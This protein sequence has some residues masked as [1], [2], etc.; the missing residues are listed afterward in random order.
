MPF[1]ITGGGTSSFNLTLGGVTSGDNG[2]IAV[3]LDSPITGPIKK[4]ATF[5]N[6]TSTVVNFTNLPDGQ[7]QFFT[8][9]ITTLVTTGSVS[10]DYTGLMMPEPITVSGTTNKS[11]NLTKEEAGGAK[12]TITVNITGDLVGDD[13][14]IFAGSPTGFKVKTLTATSTNLSAQLF[15]PDGDW[16]VGMG[17]AMPKDPTA[18][19]PPMPDW[20]PPMPT[21]VK[22]S[23]S[24]AVIK[25]SSGTA[26][27]GIIAINLSDQSLNTVQGTVVDGS[28]VGIANAEV[29]AYQANGGFGG[30][31]T[32]TAS[33]GS[34]TLKIPVL[35]VYTIGAFKPGL[36]N[37]NEQ[38]LN[39]DGN[40]SG[41][42][43]KMNKPA[44]TISGKVLN[45]SGNGI[46]Y[47]PVWAYKANGPGSANATTDASGNYIIYVN[48][49]TWIL[50]TDAPGV[51]WME[52]GSNLV[53]NGSSLS[54]INIK[55]NSA[56]TYYDIE[57]TI[58]ID[59]TTQTYMP[60]RAVA[61]DADGNHL[62]RSYDGMTD[63]SGNYKISAPA[64]I[65]RVDIW[66]PAYGEIERTG[67]D[68][69]PNHPANV[70]LTAGNKAGVDITIAN[71]D[72]KTITVSVTNGTADYEG[73]VIIEGV[74]MS[75]PDNPKPTNYTRSLYLKDLSE[76]A[77]IKLEDNKH[78]LFFIDIPGLGNYI[79]IEGTDAADG[80]GGMH[81]TFNDIFVNGVDRN[82][83][84]SIPDTS[85][86][87]NFV[88]I[89]GV[90]TSGGSNLENAWVWVGNPATGFNKGTATNSS[91]AYSITLPVLTS[92]YYM[93][94]ADKPGYV[95]QE[96]DQLDL[97][98][99]N[100]DGVADSA[101]NFTLNA[102]SSSISGYIY[103]DANSNG[104]KDSGEE[105]LNGWVY[106][107]EVNTGLMSHSPVDGSGAYSLGVSNGNWKVFGAADAY[108][109]TQYKENGTRKIIN[110][111]GNTSGK[112]IALESDSN[113]N[114]K[115]KNKPIT[116]ANGGVIDDTA[117]DG[118]GVKITVPANALGSSSS[119]G[120][121]NVAET[122][123]VTKTNSANPFGGKGK[124]ITA[125]DN[126]G[127]PITNL[128]DYIDIEMVYW[129]SDIDAQIDAGKLA[130]F[131]KIKAMQVSYFDSSVNDWVSLP[132]TR[133]AYYKTNSND[134]E[135]KTYS[136]T[137]S[138]TG[139]AK[140]IDDALVN[141]T[142]T[143][144]E[145][146]KLVFK[147]STNHLTIFG[148][149]TPTDG[150]APVAP[151][152]LAQTSGNG[153]SVALN[154]DDNS[155]S[156]LLEYEVYRSLSS[157]VGKTDTQVNSSQITASSFTDSSVNAWTSY[158]YTVTAVDDS[159]NES[160]IANELRVCSNN[161]VSNGTVATDCSITCNSG[162]NVSGNSCVASTPSSGGSG[163][164]PVNYC[165]SVEYDEWQNICTNGKQYRNVKSKT[166]NGCT[167]TSTQQLSTS[168]E[169]SVNNTEIQEQQENQ[170]LD[171]IETQKPATEEETI[172][173]FMEQ[174]KN[175]ISEA[176][177]VIKAEVE[178]FVNKFSKKRNMSSESQNR[179]RYIAPLMSNLEVGE[180]AQ[181]AM[182]NF[183]TYGTPSTFR[184]GEG[185]RTGVI[186]SFKSAFS[187]L[188]ENE[189][190]WEDIIKIANGRW[191][192]QTN[193]ETEAN[194][195]DAFKKIY[196]RNPDRNNPND[197]AAVTIIA[198]GL[199]PGN[200]NLDSEKTAIRIFR[201]IYGYNPA[202]ATAWDIVRA[203]AY[204]GATR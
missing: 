196:L 180:K 99:L 163:I 48:D 72:L 71:A 63:S 103:F 138:T 127:Q 140:F 35:G 119:S 179:N 156:D 139:F 184:L 83:I 188:P 74:D 78:Y 172:N 152:G 34:F 147:S 54:G 93:I 162:Y 201:S 44:Y 175:I 47:A 84:F 87:S 177:E 9:P 88:T 198:Y 94:G 95:S 32:K 14:D 149:T 51:G 3:F 77:T 112:N 19:P 49:G 104:L 90:V 20:M 70:N 122:S 114:N 10:T 137:A 2:T 56:T 154:W 204:S 85:D 109:D 136:G 96:P 66:T 174:I 60:I 45:S 186:N 105:I 118:T 132:T 117:S 171:G 166:P 170:E 101:K 167:L 31:N 67:T 41:V 148:V 159:G 115:T 150:I 128:N 189:G 16:M 143:A 76:T 165:S 59:G 164:T 57:G 79:P 123:S 169:C 24:G 43:I 161:T 203:I 173:T 42:T 144:F 190:D 50:E 192:S 21:Q 26:D 27:D 160:L 5:T 176:K 120:R 1:F 7:Y 187:K 64:G 68:D 125:T 46:A 102:H 130:D 193:K 113:W 17:P 168:R 12:A 129:K 197:D 121:M 4:I 39:I 195:E 135:W 62:G 116:P 178:S 11:I 100:N 86:N 155:E 8:E 52:Y 202:S 28:G 191:P 108:L 18:G 29:Y 145:D 194:A 151:T 146:Y 22:I 183:V 133:T 134:I 199:R 92:G 40:I 81:P 142:F 15:L 158:Y 182:L 58:T 13:I 38:A 82:V 111:S 55:P 37:G 33:D 69:Y 80:A 110:V 61:Y 97:S 75:D 107:E 157:G 185:E 23:L 181:N 106:A 89:N 53:I 91:G 65:Y 6:T 153:S 30:S 73:F 98:D 124:N 36:P 126:S 200:R 25:E 131:N 141:E